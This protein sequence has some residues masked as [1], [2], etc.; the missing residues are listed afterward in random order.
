[1]EEIREIVTKA[2]ISKGKKQINITDEIKLENKPYSV[3]GCWII[4]HNF[5]AKENNDIVVVSGNF[6]INVW[7]SLDENKKTEVVRK[8][9]SYE[10]EIYTKQIIK[11][12]IE[13]SNNILVR[14][15]KSPKCNDAKING[16][17]ILISVE[18]EL[19]AEIIGE[20]KMQVTVFNEPEIFSEEDDFEN[21]INE[22][23]LEE[24]KVE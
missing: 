16:N 14:V 21:Q 6:E 4:N 23:F 11:E 1:M 18:L 22:D 15:L 5:S 20:T 12:Y 7:Y 13:N 9:I 8:N 19:V 2:V 24:N 10:K 17:N 3:L